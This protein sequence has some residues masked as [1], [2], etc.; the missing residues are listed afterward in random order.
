MVTWQSTAHKPTQANKIAI[1]RNAGFVFTVANSL[2]HV[3]FDTE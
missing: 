1:A 3:V 2:A